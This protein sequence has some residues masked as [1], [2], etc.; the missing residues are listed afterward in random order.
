LSRR[1]NE[2]NPFEV[3]DSGLALAVLHL[4]TNRDALVTEELPRKRESGER[5]EL[6]HALIAANWALVLPVL[7][8]DSVIGI[9]ALG[10]KLSGDPYYPQDLDL[11]M[12]LANQAGIAIKNAQLYAEVVLANEYI[13]NIVATIE[14][15]VIAISG[16]G[17]VAMFNRA[18]EQLTGLAAQDVKGR[19]VSVLPA[20][21]REALVASVA[22]GQ[23][24]TEPEIE[25]PSAVAKVKPKPVICTTSPLRDPTGSV[26]GAVTVF[27]DL[28]PLKELEVERRRAERLA[29]F[30]VLA[31]GIGH[32]IKNPLVAIKTFAQLLPR[33][34]HDER[35]VED[36]GKVVTREI[37]RMES[38]V[39]RLRTLSRPGERP[40]HPLDLR[41]PLGEALE[42]LQPAFDD[43]GVVL[44]STIADGPCVVLGDH[45]ELSQVFLNLL[46]NAQEATPNAGR[47]DVELSRGEHHVRFVVADTGP[48]IPAELL[49]RVFD[50]FFTTKDHGSGL[51]LAICAGIAQG[52]GARLRAENRPSG[53]AIFSLEFPV[54]AA[55]SIPA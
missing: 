12:T 34:H 43:K 7:S 42:F 23:Q 9:I 30:E 16:A 31:S 50:P 47:V 29:Y 40:R 26:L 52:H 1:H 15:G 27:S 41:G 3:D 46:L 44:A 32:E 21:L 22:D 49:E 45:A 18:A 10:P 6:Y 13:E 39:D 19:P 8:E 28:T 33:R 54:A 55:S 48:G 25:L 14:S 35:F 53:G 11:L 37:G 2:D 20:C 51:G 24:R 5:S 4:S 17:E 36:F 38:L